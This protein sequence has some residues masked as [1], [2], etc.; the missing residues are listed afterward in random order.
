MAHLLGSQHGSPVD[1][2]LEE[3][4]NIALTDL[5]D[6]GQLQRVQNAFSDATKVASIITHPNGSPVTGPYRFC[7]LC[8][9]IIRKTKKGR[10]N[11]FYS[12][13]VIGKQNSGGPIVQTC[14]S[15]GIWDAGASI[16]VG[17]R[18]IGNFLMGQVK[19]ELIAEDQLLGYARE[20]GADEDDFARALQEVPTMSLDEFR[21][22]AQ[23][24][25]VIANELSNP[26]HQSLRQKR[27]IVALR[28]VEGALKESS[29]RLQLLLD[30]NNA[31]VSNLEINALVKLIP[32]RVRSV[33]QCDSVYLSMPDEGGRN[34]VVRG[35]DFPGSKGYLREGTVLE[36]FGSEA[37]RAFAEGTARRCGT[38]I[39][40]QNPNVRRIVFGEGFRSECLIPVTAGEEKLGV[41]HLSDTR[42]DRFT[43]QDVGFLAQVAGQIA[44]A[45]GNAL[46]YQKLSDTRQRLA[47]ENSY[48]T[49][50]IQSGERFKEIV[51]DSPELRKVLGHVSTVA[52]TDMTVM[53]NSETGTGKELIART[54]HQLSARRDR[55][56]VKLNCVAIPAGLL[57][58]ELFGHEKG[59]FTGA[60]ERKIGRFEVADGGTLFL[61]EIGDFPVELQPK[62]LRVLQEQEFER[63]GGTKPIRVNVRVISATNRSLEQMMRDGQFRA[64]LYYRLNVFPIRVPP[65]RERQGDIPQLVEY[66]VGHYARKMNRPIRR[67]PHEV[68][69][70]MVRYEWPGNV[71]ELQN[72]VQRAVILSPGDELVSPFSALRER[73][74]AP[75]PPPEERLVDVERSHILQV[76]KE[77]GGVLGGENGAAARLGIPRTTLIYKMRR[78]SIPRGVGSL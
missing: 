11:C 50:E 51:G 43:Q 21:D 64:D 8:K 53:I 30:L 5:F 49:R 2:K 16:S 72:L 77:S 75:E 41:L 6:V 26:A 23:L 7:R 54:I 57:E 59:A 3:K 4:P 9:E 14:L 37:G 22:I 35:L 29:E 15:G 67:I 76:L 12:D 17:G 46:K 70:A 45:L 56:F 13:A 1:E 32:A 52:D 55:M 69:E 78:L 18:H 27:D 31:I 62:L 20:I 36:M 38:E 63:V 58:S 71:R 33:M 42:P 61:D 44:I 60:H 25:F 47:D 19:N 48:L 65:L 74:A 24:G 39:K 40:G 66:F 34:F 28:K 68:M 73:E 10:A